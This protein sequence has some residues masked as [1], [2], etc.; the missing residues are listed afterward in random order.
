MMMMA[1][2]VGFHIPNTLIRI[3][4]RPFSLFSQVFSLVSIDSKYADLVHVREFR[5]HHDKYSQCVEKEHR[6][7]IVCC[8]RGYQVQDNRNNGEKF[9]ITC[10]LLAIINLFPPSQS[11]IDSLIISK[12][13]SL[14]PMEGM[15]RDGEMS[16]MNNGPSDA[17]R[18][19]EDG[20]NEE[21]REEEDENISSP[22]TRICEPL[23]VPIHIRRRKCSYVHRLFHRR[24]LEEDR[25]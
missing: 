18:T 16:E 19:M 5:N 10:K 14:L 21:P 8:V 2:V 20:E 22:N 17:R 11:I 25:R 6:V 23:C 1:F 9:A 4:H 7:L 12:W 3:I 13:C 15:I 24:D